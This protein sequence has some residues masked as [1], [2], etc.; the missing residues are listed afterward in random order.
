MTN[1]SKSEPVTLRG[2]ANTMSDWADMARSELAIYEHHEFTPA[3]VKKI[4]LTNN[5]IF[6][7]VHLCING[8]VQKP[9]ETFR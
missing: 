8:L 9:L 7:Y 1:L 5:I 3:A 4:N 6:R 2:H